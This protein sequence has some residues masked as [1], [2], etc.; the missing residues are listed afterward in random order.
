M[1]FPGPLED[2]QKEASF[3]IGQ[4]GIVSLRARFPNCF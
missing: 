4:Q 1:S 3:Q 2:I